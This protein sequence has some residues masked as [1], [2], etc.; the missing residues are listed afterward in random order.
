[1]NAAC[2]TRWSSA[3]VGSAGHQGLRD[4]PT[5]SP[6]GLPGQ[7]GG[8]GSPPSSPPSLSST[9]HICSHRL[10]CQSSQR[11]HLQ[12]VPEGGG[13][14]EAGPP[15]PPPRP[16]STLA[17]PPPPPGGARAAHPTYLAGRHHRQMSRQAAGSALLGH[18]CQAGLGNG[19]R[20]D[21]P[22]LAWQQVDTVAPGHT[23]TH[24]S[25]LPSPAP[26]A[27]SSSTGPSKSVSA[28]LTSSSLGSQVRIL[29]C[30]HYLKT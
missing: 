25:I 11:W 21:C 12:V 10:A 7:V 19:V 20:G 6:G 4:T 2:W 17:S 24:P 5:H 9:T 15:T 27:I 30:I 3:L 26:D 16:G 8:A 29:P 13:D 18:G 23:Q 22:T 28:I 1:M 14:D